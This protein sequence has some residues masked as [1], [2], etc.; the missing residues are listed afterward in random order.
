[1]LEQHLSTKQVC[2]LLG[3]S[4]ST[5]YRYC[6]VGLL[7]PAF[8]TIG[9]HRRFSLSLLRQ[10]F[11]IGTKAVLTV[12]Y[13]RVSS[14]DQKSDLISQEAKLINFAKE[15]SDF[16]HDNFVSIT[17][18]GSGLNYEKA[19]L[20]K[21]IHLIFSGQV[22]NLIIN[23]KDRLLRFGSEL[24]FYL[25]D[26]FK[27]RVII[28]EEKQEQSFEQTLSSDVIELMTVFCAKLYGKRSHKNKQ[29]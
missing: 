18:L 17:D 3:I 10:S 6:K 8:F 19:G 22:K 15:L 1:M 12:A 7:K 25:C 4:L 29:K 16:N 20:K 26:L 5:F 21:L 9:K 14:H 28:V 11:N 27:V 23:H 24:I 2:L 13:S